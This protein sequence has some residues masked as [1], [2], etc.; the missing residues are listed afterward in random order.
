M[1][2]DALR[3]DAYGGLSF[4]PGARPILSH[5]GITAHCPSPRNLPDET[6]VRIARSGGLIG[7]G[8]WEDVVCGARP[9]DIAQAIAAA[10]ELV[11]EDHVSLGSD[12]DGSVDAPFDAA[13]LWALTQALLDRG[14]TT[15]RIAKIMGGNMMAYLA[16]TLPEG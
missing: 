6:L 5:T 2:R 12:W 3:A 1:R 4:G 14:L 11:G 9:D 16:R 15:D 13:H 8:F 7:V 10:I